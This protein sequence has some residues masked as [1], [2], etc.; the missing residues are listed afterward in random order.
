M[1]GCKWHNK[2]L[3]IGKDFPKDA[4]F[5]IPSKEIE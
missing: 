2:S 1:G 5:K 4:D 3:L